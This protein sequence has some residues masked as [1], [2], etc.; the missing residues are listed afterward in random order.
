MRG[1]RATGVSAFEGGNHERLWSLAEAAS[2]APNG[3]CEG[4]EFVGDKG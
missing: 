2:D 1:G 4:V 3:R